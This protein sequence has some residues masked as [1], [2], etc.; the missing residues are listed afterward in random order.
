M[1]QNGEKLYRIKH[2]GVVDADGH[3][4]EDAG[5]WEKHSPECLNYRDLMVS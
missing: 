3:V 2:K 1:T 4:L 5:L